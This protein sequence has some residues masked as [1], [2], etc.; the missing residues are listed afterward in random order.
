[1]S[2]LEGLKEGKGKCECGVRNVDWLRK[3]MAH[4]MEVPF[5]EGQLSVWWQCRGRRTS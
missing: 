1:M 3:L 2:F 4:C 5:E